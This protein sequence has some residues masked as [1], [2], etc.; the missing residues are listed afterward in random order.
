M[1]TLRYSRS[2]FILALVFSCILTVHRLMHFHG[3]RVMLLLFFGGCLA[4]SFAG[5]LLVFNAADVL[6]DR[7]DL[8]R[9]PG[10]RRL[11]SLLYFTIL[12][13]VWGYCFFTC[14][15]G[16]MLYDTGTSILWSLG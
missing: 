10:G 15:P 5:L 13:A 4:A 3:A 11:W 12:L 6:S 8:R 16:N 7:R 9:L 2:S 14:C 1:R